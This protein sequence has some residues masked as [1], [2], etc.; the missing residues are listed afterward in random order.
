MLSFQKQPSFENAFFIYPESEESL[1]SVMYVH[2][3]VNMINSFLM[4]ISSPDLGTSKEQVKKIEKVLIELG[5]WLEE[6]KDFITPDEQILLDMPYSLEVNRI[7]LGRKR[8][9]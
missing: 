7:I 4:D 6:E 1:K 9:V 3:S 5:E 2:V 8:R